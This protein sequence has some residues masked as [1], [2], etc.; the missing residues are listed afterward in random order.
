MDP[1][2]FSLGPLE[3]RWYG[4]M[5][6]ASM[7]LGAFIASTLLRKIGRDGEIVWD[8]LF[9]VILC[10]ILGA[11]TIYVVTNFMDYLGPGIPFWK[12][13]AVWE[14]GLSF[15]GGI[16]GGALAT[17]F[18]FRRLDVPM[19]EI[20]DTFALGVSPGIMLVRFGNFMNG[21]ILGYRW[22]GP[23]AMNF[24]N[25]LYHI[26]GHPYFVDQVEVL[27]HPT[28]LYGFLVGAITFATLA[29]LWNKVYIQKTMKMGVV[30]CAFPF[31]YSLVRCLI[32]EPF[33]KVPQALQLVNPEEVGFGMLTY[34]HVA[35]IPIIL[36]ALWGFSQL[37]KWEK[38]RATAPTK[39]KSGES[40]QVQRAGKR[41]SKKRR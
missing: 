23:W 31:T 7:L 18:Y 8:G 40:R 33:R 2:A 37:G 12:V 41:D 19:I 20:V 27:R 29:F 4:I 14:G 11:R 28:E 3:I 22:E 24:P 38:L 36:I 13:I 1:V 35:S 6:A 16:I 17:Y 34:T 25:D 10:G 30:I 21:D 26:P 5:M 9:W 15:H 32:E 39:T